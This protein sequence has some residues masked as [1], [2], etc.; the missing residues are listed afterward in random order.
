M[1]NPATDIPIPA[2]ASA[3]IEAL[4]RAGY[5]SWLVGGCVRDALLG[6]PV[7]DYDIA[8]AAH[9]KDTERVLKEAGF[10]VHRTGTAHGTVT[11]SLEG[12]PLEITT[13]RSDG[14]YSDG[15]HP[16][17]VEFVRS[18]EEDLARRDF[19]VN[20]LAYHHERGLLDCWNGLNDLNQDVIR[21]VGEPAKRFREDALRVLRGCRF[22]SQLGFSI[23]PATLQ[24]MESSKMGLARISTERIVHELD[25]L[26]LGGHVHDALME[27]VDVLVAVLP[28]LA[29]CKGFEQHSPYHIYDVLEHT[30]W[31]VQRSPQTRLG[32]WSALLH[33][34]GK[35]GAFFMDGDRGHFYGH[36][37]LSASMAQDVAR[38]MGFSQ[39]FASQLT[40]LVR[41]HDTQIEATPKA[42]K[43][44]LVRMGGD[45]SLFGAL[46]DLK[47][48]DALAHSELGAARV[49]LANDLARVLDEV[50]AADEAFSLKQLALNGRDVM[51][52]GVT[53][54]PEIGRVLGKCLEAVV[55]ERIPNSHEELLSLARELA[56]TSPAQ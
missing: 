43:R 34:V 23:E 2:Y 53:E 35:P 6:R 31:V 15:R 21:A 52:L 28:E 46:C 9:W 40:T 49:E 33:D 41:E 5:E 36:A 24:A 42:V 16:D 39:A 32:R 3:A 17:S 51:E 50:I 8:T 20:A 12:N 56:S 26:L 25:A 11:A 19:T 27:T 30:A 1:P 47:R 37:R 29:A 7:N 4:E 10:E 18:I 45:V 44:M 55:D 22:A 48:A 38:R 14:A 13:F 54:G